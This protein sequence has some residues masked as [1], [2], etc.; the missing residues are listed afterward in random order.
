MRAAPPVIENRR[1]WA[2]FLDIDGTLI[3]IAQTPDSVI[4]S[5]TL[6]A[7]LSVLRQALDGALA[8]IS[9]R[10][11]TDIDRMFSGQFDAAG[12][13]GIEWRHA[14][15]TIPND[16]HRHEAITNIVPLIE[17]RA[18]HLPGLLIEKKSQSLALHYRQ[19]PELK[20]DA[21]S[22]AEYAMRELG[23]DF[24]LLAGH[25]VVEIIAADAD[26]GKAIERFMAI[27]PYIGRIPIFAGDDVTDESGFQVINRMEGIS[28]KIGN[29]P[30]LLAQFHISSPSELKV[31]LAAVATT[32][33]E[34]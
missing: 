1:H 21:W 12:T 23:E 11:L 30:S 22:L 13:H 17:E 7:L 8:L 3:D 29:P 20:P 26:K 34:R 24:R 14:G 28:I 19:N 25:S 15:T 18:Y 5:A 6:P 2:L 4:I 9:G 10:A 33:T 31:W 27:P 32:L 16:R